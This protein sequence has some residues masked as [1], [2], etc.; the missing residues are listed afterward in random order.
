MT[1]VRERNIERE[2]AK[3]REDEILNSPLERSTALAGI[4]VY[5]DDRR[6]RL[7]LIV[8][9]APREPLEGKLMLE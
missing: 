7:D 8:Q 6:E 3:D 9:D 2:G 4:G 5:K 1:R